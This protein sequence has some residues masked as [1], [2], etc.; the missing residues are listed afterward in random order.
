M[1]FRPDQAYSSTP[2]EVIWLADAAMCMWA[3]MRL[4]AM[5]ISQGV[6]VATASC[7]ETGDVQR[8]IQNG[9]GLVVQGFGAVGLM[10]ADHI[11][12]HIAARL[13]TRSWGLGQQYRRI[14]LDLT[15]QP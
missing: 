12:Q 13:E 11:L 7:Y 3:V 10:S 6:V 9:G 4:S 5:P 8:W 15:Y 14:L 1:S 2:P